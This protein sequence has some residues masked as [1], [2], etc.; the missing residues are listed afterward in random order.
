MVVQRVVAPYIQVQ[1]LDFTPKDAYSKYFYLQVFDMGLKVLVK[2]VSCYLGRRQ[3]WRATADCKSV[4]SGEWVRIP[5]G[6]PSKKYL[7]NLKKYV[8]IFLES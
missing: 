3:S 4:P 1:F 5:P 2:Y 7:T 6:L 8:I